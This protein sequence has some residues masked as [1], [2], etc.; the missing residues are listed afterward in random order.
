MANRFGP[1]LRSVAVLPA[2]VVLCFVP[3]KGKAADDQAR[4]SPETVLQRGDVS[5]RIRVVRGL[6]A[7]NTAR[8]RALLWKTLQ[9][10]PSP[11]VRTACLT[12]L[13][14]GM[15]TREL[16][17][18]RRLF[19]KEKDP[20]VRRL[21]LRI[22]KREEAWIRRSRK[23][24]KQVGDRERLFG[25]LGETGVRFILTSGAV[26]H[27]TFD[28]AY[29]GPGTLF[30]VGMA[31]RWFDID[32]AFEYLV[33]WRHDTRYEL[34]NGLVGFSVNWSV[35][36]RVRMRTGLHVGFYQYRWEIVS[37][38]GLLFWVHVL[39]VGYALSDFLW[40]E[41]SPANFGMPWG[42]HASLNFRFEI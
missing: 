31:Y 8:A 11:R 40:I 38:L 3:M 6:G 14:R 9:R 10:D 29:Y 20:A 41:L 37:D 26:F 13:A 39:D 36:R 12:A 5:R 24:Q 18:L 23:P 33:W 15:R 32:A 22:I 16:P 19:R 35:Y 34:F 1:S 27:S 28:R 30:R 21:I 7:L 42:Y 2:V 4:W 17:L 25:P